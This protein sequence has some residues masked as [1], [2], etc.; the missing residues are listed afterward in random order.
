MAS[1][2]FALRLLDLP[3]VQK[4]LQELRELA[5]MHCHGC[6]DEIGHRHTEM[7]EYGFKQEF[8][9][10]FEQLIPVGT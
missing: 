5:L 4:L 8:I 6:D 1:A 9:D 10:G 3:E 7:F 2:E